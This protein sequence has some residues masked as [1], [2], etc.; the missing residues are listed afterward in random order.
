MTKGDGV[1]KSSRLGERQWY[2]RCCSDDS[3]VCA[4]KEQA[5][6]PCQIPGGGDPGG[7][8]KPIVVRGGAAD[9]SGDDPSGEEVGE[10]STG[11]S[12]EKKSLEK[13]RAARATRGAPNCPSRAS[14]SGKS[15]ARIHHSSSI[16]P[17]VQEIACRSSPRYTVVIGRLWWLNEPIHSNVTATGVLSLNVSLFGGWIRCRDTVADVHERRSNEP[18]SGGRAPRGHAPGELPGECRSRSALETQ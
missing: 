6:N 14:S 16:T 15:P 13:P 12:A 18:C 7:G 11:G 4:V 9:P 3:T 10:K 5:T 2:F 8:G 17:S 1:E